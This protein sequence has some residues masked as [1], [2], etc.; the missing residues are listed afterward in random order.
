MARSTIAGQPAM[1]RAG[2]FDASTYRDLLDILGAGNAQV[3]TGTTDAI[4]FPG[5][6]ILNSATLDACTLAAPLAGA[7]PAG[8]DGKQIELID[9]TGKLHTITTPTNGIIGGKHLLTWNGTIGSNIT[10]QAW[11]GAWVPM[12]TPNGVTIS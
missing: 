12:G 3:L 1:P 8:D 10:L 4:S 6:T 7:Q 9:A 11:N 5:I 2:A